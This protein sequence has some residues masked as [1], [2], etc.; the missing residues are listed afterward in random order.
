MGPTQETLWC[1]NQ[2]KKTKV[3]AQGVDTAS[4]SAFVISLCNMFPHGGFYPFQPLKMNG[5]MV[6]SAYVGLFVH[7]YLGVPLADVENLFGE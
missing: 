2:V 3:G 4:T 5:Y 1:R 6:I 7:V